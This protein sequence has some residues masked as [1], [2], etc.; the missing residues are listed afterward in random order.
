MEVERL[1]MDGAWDAAKEAAV[2]ARL[3]GMSPPQPP[4]KDGGI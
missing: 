3:P 1:N 4:A 2:L